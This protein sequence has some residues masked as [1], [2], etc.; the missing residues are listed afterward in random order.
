MAASS[1]C[2]TVLYVGTAPPLAIRQPMTEAIA[3]ARNLLIVS[4]EMRDDLLLQRRYKRESTYEEK[5][6]PAH[7]IA[8]RR[9]ERIDRRLSQN[10]PSSS[11]PSSRSDTPCSSAVNT[12]TLLIRPL[13][14]SPKLK[15]SPSID[16]QPLSLMV[17]ETCA[18]VTGLHVRSAAPSFRRIG[19]AETKVLTAKQMLNRLD[20]LASATL[21]IDRHRCYA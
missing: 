5:S 10:S 12:P 3:C 8:Q 11:T 9:L 4:S 13:P 20:A 18:S 14:P 2:F 17:G 19:S 16:V 7:R 1:Q 15:L 21:R 6:S